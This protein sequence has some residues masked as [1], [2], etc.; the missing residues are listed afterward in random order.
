M[1]CQEG[2]ESVWHRPA[3]KRAAL[4]QLVPPPHLAELQS[5][6]SATPAPSDG[7]VDTASVVEQLLSVIA[8][9]ERALEAL[10]YEEDVSDVGSR[11]GDMAVESEDVT[12][13]DKDLRLV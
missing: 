6:T 9:A 13:A 3:L 7:F 10:G 12:D 8:A 4:S 11:V 2:K 1:Q 5:E